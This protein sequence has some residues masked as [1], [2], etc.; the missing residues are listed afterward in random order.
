[1]TLGFVFSD[2]VLCPAQPPTQLEWQWA[3]SGGASTQPNNS[4]QSEY[5]DYEFTHDIVTDSQGN[6]Y[7]IAMFSGESSGSPSF[8]GQSMLTSSLNDLALISLDCQGNL[9][10]KKEFGSDSLGYPMSLA[11]DAQDNLYISGQMDGLASNF[12][13]PMY[14]DNDFQLTVPPGENPLVTPSDFNRFSFLINYDSSGSYRWIYF[15]IDGPEEYINSVRGFR[16][17]DIVVE[18]NGTVHWMTSI[19]EGTHLNGHIT[20]AA[21][22][23]REWIVLRLDTNGNYIDFTPLPGL[24]VG[25]GGQSEVSR[26]NIAYDPATNTYFISSRYDGNNDIFWRG[27]NL[28]QGPLLVALD[29]TTGQDRW[30]LTGSCAIGSGNRLAIYDMVYDNNELFISGLADFRCPFNGFTFTYTSISGRTGFAMSLDAA[31]G[32]LNWGSNP[33]DSSQPVVAMQLNGN[34]LALATSMWP[35]TWDGI[36][37]N[38]GSPN[39]G[40]PTLVILDR[41]TGTAQAVHQAPSVI[42]TRDTFSAITVD[43]FGNYTLGGNNRSNLF[44]P[45]TQVPVIARRG[46]SDFFAA[47]IARTDCNGVPLS[48]TGFEDLK[49]IK[50]YPNPAGGSFRASGIEEPAAYRIMSLSG[51]MLQSGMLNKNMDVD[52]SGLVSGVYL[53]EVSSD[54]GST[55]IRLVKN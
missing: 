7:M 8:Q 12:P 37:T 11:L 4:S 36:S 46:P 20:V 30:L 28:E 16:S 31:T 34:E 32:A 41:A 53:V 15:P 45:P 43:A 14:W 6:T 5:Y 18:P 52:V 47:R 39:N 35:A 13:P 25:I 54:G 3:E 40:N 26:D 50:L 48:S 44:G 27:Q 10:W 33:D 29:A 24:A 38:L 17:R 21:G 42:T 9:R 1:L 55:A 2:F 22:D 51:Q 19:G 23:V 49:E